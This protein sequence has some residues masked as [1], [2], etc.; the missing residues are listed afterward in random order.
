MVE[1]EEEEE[2]EETFTLLTGL[3]NILEKD[4]RPQSRT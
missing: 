3:A 1:E 2:E 4:R